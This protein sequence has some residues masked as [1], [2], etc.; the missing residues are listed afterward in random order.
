MEPI[1]GL[2]AATFAP[3]SPEGTVQTAVVSR[4]AEYLVRSG[5]IGVFVN[6]TTGE[7]L[8]LTLEQRRQIAGAWRDVIAGD[9]LPLKLIVHVGHLCLRDAQ[10]LAA[11]A[12]G[13]G[14]DAVAVIA[15]CFY[16]PQ[17]VEDAVDWCARVAPAAPRTPLLYYHIPVMTGVALPMAE[18]VPQAAARIPTFAGLKF[19]HDDMTELGATLKVADGRFSV[20]SGRDEILLSALRVGATGAVGS[21]Y[22]LA[23]P[24]YRRVM[25]AYAA[26]DEAGAEREQQRAAS[27]VGIL[28]RYGVIP[29]GK[30]L[31][32]TLGL[33]G[34]LQP[35]LHPLTPAQAE[36]LRTE[37]TDIGFFDWSR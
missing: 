22:N 11:H 34:P 12:E 14:A 31:L 17:T 2:V 26:G 10:E 21:T 29:A 23:A 5:V 8:S 13:I 33:D 28:R 4:Y 19:T 30:V 7:G 36:S 3:M 20:L 1:K 9:R 24:L 16:K 25:A 35:P 6:G 32:A 27:F 37:L 18:F 15:P